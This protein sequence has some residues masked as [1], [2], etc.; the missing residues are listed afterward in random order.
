M[1][2]EYDDILGHMQNLL[3]EN[4][5]KKL[6]Y[7]YARLMDD[8]FCKGNIRARELAHLWSEDGVW[9]GGESGRYHGRKA[10]EEFF[11]EHALHVKFANR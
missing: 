6:Q 3:D 2:R 1:S 5:I 9:D 11:I 8:G 10:I 7:K 4:A